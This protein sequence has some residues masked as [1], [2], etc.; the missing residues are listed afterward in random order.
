MPLVSAWE[1]SL[2][3][4]VGGACLMSQHDRSRRRRAVPAML[5]KGLAPVVVAAA[6]VAADTAHAQFFGSI[7]GQPSGGY[8]GYRPYGS[9]GP[10][11]YPQRPAVADPYYFKPKRKKPAVAAPPKKDATVAVKPPPGPL[12]I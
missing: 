4:P 1:S 2:K 3:N 6:L 11:A 7:F 8:G 10:A 12:L 9:P 5:R